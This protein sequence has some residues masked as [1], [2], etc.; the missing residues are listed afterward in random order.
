M[1]TQVASVALVYASVLAIVLLQWSVFSVIVV[2]QPGNSV[3][4][5]FLLVTLSP[6]TAI[7]D[8]HLQLPVAKATHVG[9]VA[10]V[11]LFSTVSAISVAVPL[12]ESLHLT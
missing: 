10:L 9:S 2:K 3:L 1:A 8:L 6:V 4:H 7:P 11:Q 12:A 5:V